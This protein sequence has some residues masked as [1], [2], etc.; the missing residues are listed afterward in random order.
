MSSKGVGL[1]KFL[2]PFRFILLFK[3]MLPFVKLFIILHCVVHGV[4]FVILLQYVFS[5]CS[6]EVTFDTSIYIFKDF[7][8]SPMLVLLINVSHVLAERHTSTSSEQY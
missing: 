8:H 1:L 5:I 6:G 4:D 7:T 3:F 2:L